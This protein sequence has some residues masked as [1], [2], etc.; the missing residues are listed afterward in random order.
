MGQTDAGRKATETVACNEVRL[1]GR[2]AAA[3]EEKQ[4]PSGDVLVTF[5]LVVDRPPAHRRERSPTVDTI[6]CSAWRADVRRSVRRWQAGDTIE[7]SGALRRRFW[8][9]A[10]GAASRS[11]VEVASARRL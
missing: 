9:G 2:L 1:V 6:D 11:E 7:V 10:S 4:L 8:R 3:A 5:R